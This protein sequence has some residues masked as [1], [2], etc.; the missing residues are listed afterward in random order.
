MADKKARW[1]DLNKPGCGLYAHQLPSSG[2]THLVVTGVEI[3]SK[4]FQSL[5]KIGFRRSVSGRTLVRAGGKFRK[6]EF[7]D[8]FPGSFERE[9]EVSKILL[10]SSEHSEQKADLSGA[11]PLGVNYLGH[12]VFEGADGR[13]TRTQEGTMSERAP[14][15][16]DAMFLKATSED[17]LRLCADGFVRAMEGGRVMR[18]D[19]LRAFAASIFGNAGSKIESDDPRLRGVQEAVESSIFRKVAESGGRQASRD[20]FMYARKLYEHQPGMVY[21]TSESMI[22]QQ[23]STPAPMAIAAQRILGDVSTKSVLDPTIGNASLV[24]M[25]AYVAASV[26]GVEIDEVRAASAEAASANISVVRGDFLKTVLPTD[27]KFDIVIGN[28]PFGGLKPTVQH[29]G[30]KVTRIDQLIA[31][32]ALERRRDDG[33]SVFII[34][35]DSKYKGGDEGELEGGSKYFFNWMADHYVIEDAVEVNGN[36]YRKQ[37]ASFPVRMVTVGRKK[38][39]DEIAESQKSGSDRFDVVPVIHSWDDLWERAD[40]LA[41]RL[42]EKDELNAV[43][44]SPTEADEEKERESNE[45]QVPYVALSKVGEP[46]SMVPR[47]LAAPTAKALSRLEEEVGDVDVFVAERLGIDVEYLGKFPDGRSRFSPEQVDAIALGLKAQESGRGVINGDMT[48]QGKGRALAGLALAAKRA[49]QPIVFLSD[50]ANLFSDFW[51]DLRA[52][53]AEDEFN[54]LVMNADAQIRDLNTNEALFNATKPAILNK[55]MEDNVTLDETGHDLMFATYSQFNRETHKSAKSRWL[56]R[57]VNGALLILDEAHKAAGESNTGFNIANAI[58][59]ARDTGGAVAYSSATYAKGVKNLAV[60][61]AVMPRGASF[62]GMSDTLEAG[63]EQ[64]QEILAS[65]LA[66][67]GVMIRRE[68]DLSNLTFRNSVDYDGLARNEEISDRLAEILAAMSAY[69]GD[70]ET[71]VARLSSQIRSELE[72]LPDQVKAG[73]RMGVSYTNFGSRLYN[74]MR[75]FL[76]AIKVDAVADM[77]LQS[78]KEGRKP[79]IVLELTM[80]SI[81]SEAFGKEDDAGVSIMGE[82]RFDRVMTFRDVLH[83]LLARLDSIRE[84]GAYGEVNMATPEQ[85]ISR[86]NWPEDTD[87]AEIYKKLGEFRESVREMIGGFPDLPISPLDHI[88]DRLSGEGYKVGEISGRQMSVRADG[89]QTIVSKRNDDRLA[90]IADF[91]NAGTDAVIMTRAGSVGLSM[92]ASEDFKDQRQRE[93]IE[94]QIAND[95]SDRIQFFGRVNRRGAVCDPMITSVSSGI[96]AELRHLAMQ[97]A[98][99]RKL[100]ANT[101]SDRTNAA[102]AKDIPD[103]LNSIGDKVAYEFLCNEPDIASRLGISLRELEGWDGQRDDYYI[104]TLTGRIMLLK[105]DEQRAIYGRLTKMFDEAVEELESKGINPLKQDFMDIRAREVGD[106]SLLS[107]YASDGDYPS[108][109]DR[110]VYVSEIEWEEEVQ[111][112]RA[113]DIDEAVERAREAL[114]DSGAIDHDN[115][116]FTDSWN[117]GDGA[118]RLTEKLLNDTYLARFDAQMESAAKKL[119]FEDARAALGD[120][121]INL[122]KRLNSKKEF[123]IRYLNDLMP[124]RLIKYTDRLNDVVRVGVVVNARLPAAEECMHFGEYRFMIVSPGESRPYPVTLAGLLNDPEL[125]QAYQRP[126]FIK[127]EFDNAPAGMVKRRRAILTGNLYQAA[128]MCS[129]GQ[130]DGSGRVVAYSDEHGNKNRAVLLPF[131]FDKQAALE[132]PVKVTN[133]LALLEMASTQ[134]EVFLS[135]SPRAEKTENSVWLEIGAGQCTLSAPGSKA[136]GGWVTLDKPLLNAVGGQFA[137]GRE[138]MTVRFGRERLDE[139]VE[140]LTQLGEFYLDHDSRDAYADAMRRV[141]EADSFSVDPTK[142]KPQPMKQAARG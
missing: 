79:V 41:V 34:A 4:E 101:S 16:L 40:S 106:A 68:H 120:S 84:T 93:M 125:S 70:V 58:A 133:G 32:R 59:V 100:S 51:R 83:R 76:L 36:L 13:F 95:V 121:E 142:D 115:G 130:I 136:R 33:L 55:F 123:V 69:S 25:L 38:T 61:G 45:F 85:V 11:R 138:R 126:E 108:V 37:G 91:N 23:Y 52:I 14:G 56:P 26:V 2:Q 39:A 15:S 48:G 31:L 103:L 135:T 119:D 35:G 124:G 97:N 127:A 129:S 19:D 7:L 53:G 116:P 49:G 28:P 102:E 81:L 74:S 1:L 99:L 65:M 131:G 67:D 80:E 42:H 92:H 88:I 20:A 82:Q 77:A 22:N 87:V 30:L 57:A 12:E 113:K 8:A 29:Q 60:Y 54:P 62:A 18:A 112:W 66:E 111:P 6:S 114:G 140:R 27:D 86:I 105:V 10:L 104:N 141:R 118:P 44:D 134:D 96:P 139:V 128:T 64:M 98:K 5:F 78:L 107:G 110:P 89:N 46:T 122:V 17:N 72:G 71:S 117:Y 24:N 75:Q 73:N 137:G 94:L 63:G 109:F 47:H 21:R 132:T 50:K 43:I 3:G 9:F 90:V